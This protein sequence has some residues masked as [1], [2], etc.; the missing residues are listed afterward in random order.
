MEFAREG[1]SNAPRRA[2]IISGQST[3]P[4]LRHS[5]TCR[6]CIPCDEY[7]LAMRNSS[8]FFQVTRRLSAI[9][10]GNIW[11]SYVFRPYSVDPASA[12]EANQKHV[13]FRFVQSV[14]CNKRYQC[15][16]ETSVNISLWSSKIHLQPSKV[17]W[18]MIK[19]HVWSLGGNF[20][21]LFGV[22]PPFPVRI[23]CTALGGH[24]P[25]CCAFMQNTGNTISWKGFTQSSRLL[26]VPIQA[27]IA[28]RILPT[29]VRSEK[30]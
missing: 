6:Q 14:I 29:R 3:L 10:V 27:M 11:Q 18:T 16:G 8:H 15:P 23:W 1:V 22:W 4:P 28:Q 2:A 19:W 13:V 17:P 21:V 12:T 9:E 20:F 7:G 26:L 24:C 25:T 30:N 5:Q